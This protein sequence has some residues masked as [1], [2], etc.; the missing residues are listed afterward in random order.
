MNCGVIVLWVGRIAIRGK[1]Y[2]DKG[3]VSTSAS[4]KP[5]DVANNALID[6]FLTRKIR[7]EGVNWRN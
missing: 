6:F 2:E 7:I 3:N 4:C 5:I 1:E